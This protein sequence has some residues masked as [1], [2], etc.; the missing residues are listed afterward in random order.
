VSDSII[1]LN[2]ATNIGL[3]AS[4]LCRT[5][6]SQSSTADYPIHFSRKLPQRAAI[7]LQLLP[8]RR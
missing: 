2:F 7:D 8:S 4:K 5:F 1:N 6:L 3:V